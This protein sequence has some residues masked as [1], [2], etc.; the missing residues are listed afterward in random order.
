MCHLELFACRFSWT[1]GLAIILFPLAGSVWWAAVFEGWFFLSFFFLK[2][3]NLHS[4]S[5]VWR[6]HITRKLEL[7]CIEIQSGRLLIGK[8]ST[9]VFLTSVLKHK[10]G[11]NWNTVTLA[12]TVLHYITAHQTSAWCGIFSRLIMTTHHILLHAV[13]LNICQWNYKKSKI[14]LK[15]KILHCFIIVDISCSFAVQTVDAWSYFVTHFSIS[16]LASC[17]TLQNVRRFH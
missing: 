7:S 13:K 11:R 10:K 17:C 12:R 2:G 1:A 6:Q 9:G 4:K 14:I 16:I 5:S 8:I 15:T 3:E